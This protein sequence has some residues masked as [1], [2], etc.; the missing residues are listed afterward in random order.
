MT[1]RKKPPVVEPE[2]RIGVSNGFFTED[3]SDLWQEEVIGTSPE[4]QD[5]LARLSK[6]L[7]TA[8]GP[9]GT[10]AEVYVRLG[11]RPKIS[12]Q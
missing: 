6:A 1:K 12:N 4:I 3:G 2:T 5:F 7:E 10:D 11:V 8:L 9:N